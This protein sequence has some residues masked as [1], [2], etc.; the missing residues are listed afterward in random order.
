MA[1]LKSV[2][3]PETGPV[4][5]G[6]RGSAAAAD[7]VGLCGL[8]GVALIEPG[9]SHALGTDMDAKRVDPSL[10]PPARASLR[11]RGARRS[12]LCLFHVQAQ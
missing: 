6:G 5:N 9:I 7:H 4:I 3:P 10:L 1:L 12:G 11:A 8:G 2:A